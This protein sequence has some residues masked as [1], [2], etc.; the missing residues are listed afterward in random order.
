M[1]PN[2]GVFVG[3]GMKRGHKTGFVIGQVLG[4]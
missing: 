3:Q 1:A 2:K 4:G